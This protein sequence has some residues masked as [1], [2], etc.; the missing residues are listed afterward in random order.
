MLGDLNTCG[1]NTQTFEVFSKYKDKFTVLAFTPMQSEWVKRVTGCK[2]FL[3]PPVFLDSNDF[4]Y[5]VGDRNRDMLLFGGYHQ[6]GGIWSHSYVNAHYDISE[7][8]IMRRS[9]SSD[10]ESI[11]TIGYEKPIL[12]RLNYDDWIDLIKKYKY[13]IDGSDMFHQGRLGMDGLL[14]GTCYVGLMGM[15]Y[16]SYLFE[17][18]SFGM[19]LGIRPPDDILSVFNNAVS[20]VV[21]LEQVEDSVGEY[22]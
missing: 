19:D 3:Y 6:R 22:L 4:V 2:S 12:E 21:T 18:V 15:S 5:P 13:M 11:H 10:C 8:D 20:K 1:Q 9:D 7:F 16:A 14:T 17:E